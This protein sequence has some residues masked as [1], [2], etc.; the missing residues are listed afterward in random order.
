M[1]ASIPIG[2]RRLVVRVAAEPVRAR[3]PEPGAVLGASDA[4]L[5]RLATEPRS[6]EAARW[7]VWASLHGLRW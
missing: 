2:R 1:T 3:T 5:A 6:V 4:E 7:D